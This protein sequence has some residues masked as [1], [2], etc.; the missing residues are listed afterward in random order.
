MSTLNALLL[1]ASVVG[2]GQPSSSPKAP[3]FIDCTPSGV[4]IQSTATKVGWDD[5][6]QR[7]NALELVLDQIQSNKEKEYVVV[8]VRPQSLKF[9]RQVRN[10]IAKR[11]VD[12]G[13]E[14]L[15]TDLQFVGDEVTDDKGRTLTGFK[16]VPRTSPTE[17]RPVFFECRGNDVFFVD[18]DSLDEQVRVKLSKL[19]PS[20]RSGDVSTF[21]KAIQGEEIKNNYYR[22]DPKFLLVGVLA[23]ERI[24]GVAGEGLA[25]LTKQRSI[26]RMV[27]ASMNPQTEYAAFLVRD[28]SFAVYRRARQIVESKGISSG[29][30]LLGADEPIKF[31][32]D[33]T[34]IGPQ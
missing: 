31:G 34:V 18:K 11:Q 23:L 32:Q 17:K 27:T 10:M 1:A 12:V 19:N 5:L 25:D 16:L 21:L 13:Y 30:E 6:Q 29:W 28:D 2:A 9:Y 24:P 20:V 14:P 26:F 33:G 7:G 8:I 15:D 4:I 22:V 3:Q